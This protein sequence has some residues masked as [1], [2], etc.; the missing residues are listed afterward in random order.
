MSLDPKKL[1]LKTVH[2]KD[3]YFVELR[4]GNRKLTHP[5]NKY[6]L[7]GLVR[8][9]SPEYIEKSSGKID[10]IVK[11]K[12]NRPTDVSNVLIF[13]DNSWSSK[14]FEKTFPAQEACV[15][16][17][18]ILPNKLNDPFELGR[19]ICWLQNEV[20]DQLAAGKYLKA[21]KRTLSLSRICF[22]SSIADEIVEYLEGSKE[23]LILE[24]EEIN[25]LIQA[26]ELSDHSERKQW[27][28]DLKLSRKINTKI[29][30]TLSLTNEKNN[31]KYN[32]VPLKTFAEEVNSKICGMLSFKAKAA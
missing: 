15:S 26:V 7:S 22:L 18:V 27:V 4:I 1:Q 17:T 12:K 28:N 24:N 21:I 10:Y 25:A 9:L 11:H 19:Y 16:P 14:A 8:K 29:L 32:D 30:K 31:Y 5:I 20:N 6:I 3:I 13:C 2:K 23:P